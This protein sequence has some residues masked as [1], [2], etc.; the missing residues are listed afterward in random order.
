MAK[1]WLD[2]TMPEV[3]QQEVA[4]VVVLCSIAQNAWDVKVQN[5]N[6]LSLTVD[7]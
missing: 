4:V 2:E 6:S 5:L 3:E 1:K 7:V